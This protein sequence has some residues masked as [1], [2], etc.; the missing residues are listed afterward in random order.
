MIGRRKFV[1]LLGG[2]AAAFSVSLPAPGQP[3]TMPV[4]GYLSPGSLDTRVYLVAAFRKGLAETGYVEGR[5]VAIE[6]RWA[7]NQLDTVP[8]LLAELVQRQVTVIAAPGGLAA[9][10]AAKASAS[11]IPVVFSSAA[12][13]VRAGIVANLN[14]PGGNITGVVDMSVELVAKQL[15]L[16][17]E[18][19]PQ[20][21]RFAVL[22]NPTSPIAEPTIADAQKAAAGISRHVEILRAGTSREIDAA[23]AGLS[24]TR[25]DAILVSPDTLFL[26]RRVQLATLTVRHAVPAIFSFREHPEAGALMSYGSSLAERDRLTGVYTGRVLKGE[27]PRD[28]PI[29]QAVKF[30]LVVNLHSSEDPRHRNPDQPARPRRRG[31]RMIARREV[32]TLLGGATAAWPLQARAQQAGKV[33]RIGLLANDPS[34]PTTAPGKAFVDG[35]AEHGFVEGRNLI[36]ER[37]FAMADAGRHDALAAELVRLDVEVLV[38]SGSSSTS[39]ASRATK[40]GP[41]VMLNVLDPVSAG[42]VAGLARPGGNITGLSSHVSADMA[43]KRLAL[44]KEAVPAISRMAVLMDR[45][46]PS[47]ED[48]AQWAELERVAPSMGV[49]LYAATA[50]QGP[51]F[52]GALARI[53]GARIDALF[54]SYNGVNLTNRKTVIAFAAAHRLPAMYPSTE[55]ALDGGLM[56]YGASRADLFRRSAAY[57][58]KILKGAKPADLPVEQPVKF[59]FVINLK[60]AKALGLDVPPMLLARADEVIE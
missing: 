6:Y 56:S 42:F 58:A 17:H 49:T 21:T 27:K 52:E 59:E 37:R 15:G 53:A 45:D 1:G 25:A 23:F 10:R 60:T 33:H 30:E 41:I 43:G 24:Q 16:L 55:M 14:R 51:G 34:I 28:L 29:M 11:T 46:P 39:A 13:P 7:H 57:V 22:V 2:G 31:D 9:A 36:I 8:S 38:T 32:I 18:L 48:Q 26:T 40:F 44:L 5:N 35:L 12:D 19:L 4:I 47:S 54:A 50:Q 20:A 3:P